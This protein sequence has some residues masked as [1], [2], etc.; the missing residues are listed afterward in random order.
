MKKLIWVLALWLVLPG[1]TAWADTTVVGGSSSTPTEINASTAVSP[2]AAQLSST[3]AATIHNQGQGAADINVTLPA[4][5]ANLGFLGTVSTAQAGNYWRFTS[6]ATDMYLNGS[7]TAKAYVQYTTPTV[8][9]YFSCFTVNVGGTYKWYC[10][11][12][13]GTLATN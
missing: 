3:N 9:Y 4:A 11:D 12:G 6:A 1:T 8:G 10:A 13:V 7:A 5:A 2:T